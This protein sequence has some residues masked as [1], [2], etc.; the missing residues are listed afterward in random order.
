MVRFVN[1]SQ[2]TIYS[3]WVFSVSTTTFLETWESDSLESVLLFNLPE[4]VQSHGG[5]QDNTQQRRLRR[6]SGMAEVARR[7]DTTDLQLKKNL[8]FYYRCKNCFIARCC[9]SLNK[10]TTCKNLGT[11]DE[12]PCS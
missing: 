10:V 4:T 2:K 12:C 8:Q 6:D 11:P 9:I 3:A 7:K 5:K 1:F